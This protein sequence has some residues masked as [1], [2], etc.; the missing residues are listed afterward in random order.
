MEYT[1]S[2]EEM[3]MKLLLLKEVADMLRIQERVLYKA[4][5]REQIGLRSIKI[6]GRLRFRQ[7]DVERLITDS[8]E[9]FKTIGES[10]H[11]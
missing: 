6:G 11:E 2:T 10:E 1:G 3:K 4:R 8:L 9:P 7:E 5:V